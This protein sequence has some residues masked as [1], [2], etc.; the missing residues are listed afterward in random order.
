MKAGRRDSENARVQPQSGPELSFLFEGKPMTARK[1]DTVA[2]ALFRNGVR[3]FG[4]SSK[5]HRPRG[6]RCGMGHCSACAMRV[7]GLPGVRTCVTP[8]RE[9][10][11]VAREHA[12]P[13][14]RGDA[15]R[16]AEALS[17]LMP[18]GFYYRWFRRSPRLWGAFE[19]EQ[20]K[21]TQP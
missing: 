10:M 4:R 21:W 9:G 12:W 8:V 3:V 17:P 20:I 16:V 15:L 1:G 5:Y 18:P 6:Y 11:T 13:G 2:S 14:A 7:D 19:R